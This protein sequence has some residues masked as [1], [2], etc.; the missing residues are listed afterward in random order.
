MELVFQMQCLLRLWFQSITTWG[1]LSR[2]IES[3][4]RYPFTPL[5]PQFKYIARHLNMT[6][7]SVNFHSSRTGSDSPV[8]RTTL[9]E[10][11]F[12]LS[13]LYMVHIFIQA[14]PFPRFPFFGKDDL[15]WVLANQIGWTELF[16]CKLPLWRC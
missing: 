14:N 4:L 2:F 11:P 7:F 13:Y 15:K 16:I 6:L 9:Y 3:P 1:I 10:Y 8:T 5:S 12:K